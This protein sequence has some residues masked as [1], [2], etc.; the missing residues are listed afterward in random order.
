MFN[1][2]QERQPTTDT[3][4]ISAK[5]KLNE[6]F[7]TWLAKQDT[8]NYIGELINGLNASSQP[9]QQQQ[10]QQKNT[11][12][13][14]NNNNS[15]NSTTMMTVTSN[16][17]VAS[18]PNTTVIQSKKQQQHQQQQSIIDEKTNMVFA[19][20]NMIY[21]DSNRSKFNQSKED[22]CVPIILDDNDALV[23]H[24]SGSEPAGPSS[25]PG[26]P[27]KFKR[28]LTSQQQDE[29]TPVEQ[30][31]ERKVS[32]RS[33]VIPPFYKPQSPT[34]SSSKMDVDI[35]KIKT[36]FESIKPTE[37]QLQ[38]QQSLSTSPTKTTPTLPP[39]KY[40]QS[41]EEFDS[42]IKELYTMP[43]VII[44]LLFNYIVT[45]NDEKFITQDVF[46]KYWKDIY[47]RK[48]EEILFNL[49]RKSPSST[50][51]TYEDFIFFAR[52]LLDFHPGLEF[53]KNTP[54]FQERYLETIIVR[55]FYTI[56]KKKG[57]ITLSDLISNNF[58]K[59]LSLLDAEADINKHLEYF[60]Y[61]HFYVIYCKFWELDTDHDLYISAQDL[62]KYSN[63]SLTEK[64][65]ARIIEC[66]IFTD[67]KTN[68]LS[69][70]NFVWFILSEE[71]KNNST[72]I[73]YWFNCLDF[74][75]DGILS[76]H[77]M[78]YFYND[79][80]DRLD[81]LNLDPPVFTDLLCQIID[82]I[83]P[84]DSE[85]ITLIDLK[86]SKLSGYLYNILFNTTKF[87]IQ[88]TKESICTSDPSM[89]DWNRFAKA[90]Y[91]KALAEETFEEE[92]DDDD[93]DEGLGSE[94]SW[95]Q[96]GG[97]RNQF[98]YPSAFEDDE[99]DRDFG[100]TLYSN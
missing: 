68:L 38:Q 33:L 61:E 40:L 95:Y 9:Q 29:L 98:T 1:A 6:L 78:E 31:H 93:M 87:F 92:D 100:Q 43:R 80:K 11:S 41:F 8:V 99:D 7:L 88:E 82:M 74:D 97:G 72:S 35:Q 57:R 52:T 73:E 54:E 70:K 67:S 96:V 84:K 49:L 13:N 81:N 71:D 28:N 37:Q 4:I 60:S 12:N 44:R 39:A 19:D 55:I 2:F 22:E 64:M 79:Q 15:T 48:P 89:S 59:S 30:L 10:Q 34:V 75:C 36:R 51:L 50:Y 76:Y 65:I 86:N 26:S 46:I 66:P 14:N 63:F 45:L 23:A 27:S 85:R 90:E 56:S 62:A 18:I 17:G 53:L 69:Y 77:E 83:K 58:I 91:E 94:H 24:L 20:D 32:K 42:L 21:E 47:N 16:I 3:N 5:L 25:S